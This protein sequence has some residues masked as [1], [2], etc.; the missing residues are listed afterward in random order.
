MD[1]RILVDSEHGAV[2]LAEL[3]HWLADV[4]ELRGRLTP[5]EA[6]PPPGVLGPTLEALLLAIA[7]GSVAT[8]FATALVSWLRHRSGA[9]RVE[10]ELPDGSRV[11]LE[12]DRVREMTD[13]ELRGQLAAVLAGLSAGQPTG[14]PRVGRDRAPADEGA[15]PTG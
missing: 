5:L 13:A 14:A 4:P 11:K 12:A 10:L 7:P 15:A 2:H 9:V 3:H 8:A 1:V 6:P